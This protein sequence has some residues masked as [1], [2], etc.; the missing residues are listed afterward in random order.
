MNKYVNSSGEITDTMDFIQIDS[1]T[2]GVEA[3][4]NVT[5]FDQRN[6][7]LGEKEFSEAPSDNQ[8]IFAIKSFK[9]GDH[10]RVDKLYYIA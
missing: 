9:D 6:V 2:N 5:V 1:T 4:Y 3:Y 8:I 7:I 10:A